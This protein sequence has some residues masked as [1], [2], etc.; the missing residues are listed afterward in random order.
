MQTKAIFALLITA[1]TAAPSLV[2]RAATVP[3]DV[4]SGSGCNDL[5]DIPRRTNIPT[6]GSCTVV[7]GIN[8]PNRADSFRVASSLP[9]GCAG[10]P[11]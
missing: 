7:P 6:D 5:G 4:Y 2:D 9:P 10:K 11:F 1:I 3:V 8:P